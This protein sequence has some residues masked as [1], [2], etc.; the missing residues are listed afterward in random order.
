[1]N[2]DI[3]EAMLDMNKSAF[4]KELRLIAKEIKQK[5]IAYMKAQDKSTPS[6]A[7]EAPRIMTGMLA[8]SI[9][10]KVR[11]NKVIIQDSQ[12]YAR[13]LAVGAKNTGKYRKGHIEERL[14]LSDILQ[15]MEKEIK[16][17]LTTAIM[18]G[19]TSKEKKK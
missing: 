16:E 13:F 2:I 14:F 7:G 6:K 10:Y 18:T 8:S 5:M 11:G 3:N 9:S 19:L 4:R 15:S 17:R 1:M 12:Y